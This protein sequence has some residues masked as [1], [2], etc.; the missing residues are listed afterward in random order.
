MRTLWI[1]GDSFSESWE[2]V[3]Q[4]R[5]SHRQY[6][7][8]QWLGRKPHHF[9]ET[10][11][12]IVNNQKNPNKITEIRN[13]GLGGYDNYSILATIGH[14]IPEI[15]ENDMV[16]IGWSAITRW[17]FMGSQEAKEMH[18]NDWTIKNHPGY[19]KA[20]QTANAEWG[21]EY[22]PASHEAFIKDQPLKRMGYET[23]KEISEWQNILKLALPKDTVFWSPFNLQY[24]KEFYPKDNWWDYKRLPFEVIYY[25]THKGKSTSEA[26]AFKFGTP[27]RIDMHTHHEVNDRHYSENGHVSVGK[28]LMVVLGCQN[29]EEYILKKKLL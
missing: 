23:V 14:H 12:E 3:L 25:W 10:I 20:W 24:L 6:Q 5:H 17:R 22:E 4:R 28:R 27:E 19:T 7:Y 9:S 26:S 18:L 15:K 8:C 11:Q 1:F 16:M 13:Y 2:G 21:W 29:N